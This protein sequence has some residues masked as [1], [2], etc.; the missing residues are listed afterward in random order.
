MAN[1]ETLESD[2][3]EW[4]AVKYD[5]P[6]RSERL[7]G[8]TAPYYR[9]SRAYAYENWVLKSTIE[10]GNGR[11]DHSA[12]EQLLGQMTRLLEQTQVQQQQLQE[13]QRQAEEWT[14]QLIE[15]LGERRANYDNDGGERQP[16]R[17]QLRRPRVEA[18]KEGEDVEK[19][20]LTF[21]Q[22]MI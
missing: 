3:D 22:Q 13:Q 1:E 15:H 8:R 11:E 2:L 18:L 12:M 17:D 7:K 14:A 6:R 21:E 10:T 19:F 9:D 16:Y 4:L 20:L 5:Q